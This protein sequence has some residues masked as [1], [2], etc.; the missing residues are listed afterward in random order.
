MNRSDIVRRSGKSSSDILRLKQCANTFYDRDT[1]TR[2]E[3]PQG[4]PITRHQKHIHKCMEARIIRNFKQDNLE[5]ILRTRP[6]CLS[7][8]ILYNLEGI[9]IDH[10]YKW[11]NPTFD[12]SQLSLEDHDLVVRIPHGSHTHLLWCLDYHKQRKMC[13]ELLQYFNDEGMDEFF[14]N[15]FQQFVLRDVSHNNEEIVHKQRAMENMSRL[16]SRVDAERVARAHRLSIMDQ[17]D[18]RDNS[19]KAHQNLGRI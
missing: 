7:I 5:Q 15:I 14:P 12:T 13:Q 1:N 10:F 19:L 9:G 16:M 17:R 6:D 2:Y 3:R 11:F 18:M 4:A 8:R